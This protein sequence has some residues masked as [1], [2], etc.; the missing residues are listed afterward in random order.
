[1][2]LETRVEAGQHFPSDVL[3]RIIF[4][5]DGSS[6]V[7]V[8]GPV[9]SGSRDFTELFGLAF[10]GRAMYGFS[11]AGELVEIDRETGAGSLATTA[12]GTGSFWGAGVTTRAPILF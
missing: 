7:T 4:A 8:I 3:V 2:L 9:Q 5:S 10:W 1:L 12:T 6:A 11:N